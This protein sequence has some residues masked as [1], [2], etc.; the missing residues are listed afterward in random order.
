[1]KKLTWKNYFDI[2]ILPPEEVSE[3]AIGLS[4]KLGRFETKWALGKRSF[5]PHISLYH[6]AVMPKNYATFIAEIERTV[7]NFSSGYLRTTVIEPNLLMFDK[8]KWI[9]ELYLNII[10][11]TL[12][13]YD[14]DYG[15]DAHWPLN[16]FPK[17]MR[18]NGKRF[19]EKYGTPMVGTNF[20]PHITLTDFI[21]QP[22]GLKTNNAK[23]FKFRPRFIY[24][25][26]LGPSHSCQRIVTKIPFGKK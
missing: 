26:E 8:P 10:K 4:K 15:T 13:Y 5:I 22:P 20:R 25:C 12:K 11:N 16:H 14:W 18:K 24:V 7:E 21:T 19:M 9:K 3:Y 2:V 23:S 17:K 1:M 6:I